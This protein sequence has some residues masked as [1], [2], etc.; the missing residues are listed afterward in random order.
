MERKE[1]SKR[2]IYL[3]ILKII[4]MGMVFYV[5]TGT[6]AMHHYSI[7]GER[8]SYWI[9]LVLYVLATAGPTVFFFISGGL[10]LG[11]EESLKVV[12]LKRVLRYAILLVGFKIIQLIFLIKTNPAYQAIPEYHTQPVSSVL[13]VVY[14]EEEPI[15]PAEDIVVNGKATPGSTAF[16][17]SAEGLIIAGE[18]I[19][20]LIRECERN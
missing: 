3:D 7:S 18:V 19:K 17:P 12:L 2:K 14:S 10:L 15:K 9:S 8:S 1:N 13:K 5:H 20:D 4:A 11:K 6:W 16:V